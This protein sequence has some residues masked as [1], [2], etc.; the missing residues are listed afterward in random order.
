MA[1]GLRSHSRES[2]HGA[3]ITPPVADVLDRR[4]HDRYPAVGRLRLWLLETLGFSEGSLIDISS[5][6][7]RFKPAG[8]VPY[9]CLLARAP[10]RIEVYGARGDSFSGMGEVRHTAGGTIGLKIMEAIPIGLF[11]PDGA[12]QHEPPPGEDL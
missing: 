2:S 3:V 7:L 10:H 1:E 11:R 5:H 8:V 9:R 12:A 6:G 4:R